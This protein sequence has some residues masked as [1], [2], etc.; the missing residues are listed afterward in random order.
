M[1]KDS[2]K[3]LAQTS[4][5]IIKCGYQASERNGKTAKLRELPVT[6]NPINQSI[7]YDNLFNWII[8]HAKSEHILNR[9]LRSIHYYY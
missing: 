2:A 4:F 3:I 7:L 8:R 1:E 9:W 6:D 5:I